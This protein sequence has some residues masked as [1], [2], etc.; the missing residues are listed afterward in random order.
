MS[1]FREQK[2]VARRSIHSA[3]SEPVL[4]VPFKEGEPVTLTARLHL[5]FEALGELRRSGFAEAAELTPKAIFLEPSAAIG[6]A[7]IIVTESMGA[8]Q[9]EQVDPPNDITVTASISRLPAS[10]YLSWGLT[11]GQPWSG[12]PAPTL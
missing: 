8:F 2:R 10:Q 11:A 9:I 12:L 5:S 1:T 7:A 4:Y 3:L 6:R